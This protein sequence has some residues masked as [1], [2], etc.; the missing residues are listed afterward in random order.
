MADDYE[1]ENSNAQIEVEVSDSSKGITDVLTGKCDIA[2]VSRQLYQYE[3]EVLEA[4]AV[5]KDGIRVI[6]NEK[7]SDRRYFNGYTGEN[8]HWKN[9]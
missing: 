1:K 3:T 8:L 2:M 5:A 6:V 4:E 7:K 9:Q